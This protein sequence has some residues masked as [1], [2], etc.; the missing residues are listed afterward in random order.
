MPKLRY[1]WY[2]DQP[3]L[4]NNGLE[5]HERLKIQFPHLII[6]EGWNQIAHPGAGPN[7]FWEVKCKESDQFPTRPD[8]TQYKKEMDEWFDE[9]W[10]NLRSHS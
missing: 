1:L 7:Q 2:R 9:I 5:V 6:N 4:D 10:A 3:G 8:L